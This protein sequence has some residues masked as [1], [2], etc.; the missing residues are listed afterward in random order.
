M[1]F[2]IDASVK[3]L[4]HTN[5]LCEEIEEVQLWMFHVPDLL[6]MLIIVNGFKLWGRQP[7]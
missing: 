6:S 7:L 5:S 3:S 4:P 1:F 2:H